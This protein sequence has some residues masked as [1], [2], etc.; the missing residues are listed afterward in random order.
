M[1]V[2]E[3]MRLVWPLI[4]LQVGLQVY[5]LYDLAKNKKTRNLNLTIWAVIIIF[6]ELFGPI[7][8][9][10]FGKSEE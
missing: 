3:M 6:G 2:S 8:Y 7:L 9:L 1:N 10:I 5:A 4:A